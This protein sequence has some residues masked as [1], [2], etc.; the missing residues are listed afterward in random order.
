MRKVRTDFTRF[1]N[2]AWLDTHLATQWV[3]DTR[4]VGAHETGLGLALE[5]VDD[6][7]HM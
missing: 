6:L 4:A 3:D 1:V 7:Q 2:V 5:R